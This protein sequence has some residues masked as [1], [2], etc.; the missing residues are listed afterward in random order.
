MASDS[1]YADEIIGIQAAAGYI[2]AIVASSGIVGDVRGL[3]SI[4]LIDVRNGS[5]ASPD[6]EVLLTIETKDGIGLI[7]VCSSDPQ[8]FPA[9]VAANIVADSDENQIGDVGGIVADRFDGS[10]AG[11]NIGPLQVRAGNLTLLTSTGNA[12]ALGVFESIGSITIQGDFGIPGVL[13]WALAVNGI[14]SIAVGGNLYIGIRANY[15]TMNP[16]GHACH[17]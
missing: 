10:V 3:N 12:G 4:D 1:V 6:P 13:D 17:T 16:D 2:G 5:I 8:S 15:D 14:Y 9:R 7:Q 11:H